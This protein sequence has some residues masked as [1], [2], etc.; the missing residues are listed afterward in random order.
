ML[1]YSFIQSASC[2]PTSIPTKSSL[3]GLVLYSLLASFCFIVLIIIL[4]IVCSC[5]RKKSSKKRAEKK[6]T[7]VVTSANKSGK[8]VST[9]LPMGSTTLPPPP[10]KPSVYQRTFKPNEEFE[11]KGIREDEPF[12]Q[13]MTNGRCTV[14]QCTV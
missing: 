9:Y 10:P 12:L 3:S 1:K 11:L 8:D 13:T 6:D 5:S 2:S 7:Y 4:I 14:V